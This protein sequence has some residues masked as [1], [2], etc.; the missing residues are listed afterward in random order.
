LERGLSIFP[1]LHTVNAR[2]TVAFYERLQQVSGAYLIPLMPFD[3][4]SLANNYKGLFP[5]GLRTDAYAECGTAILELLLH[6]L[7][8]SNIEVQAKLSVVLNTSHNGYDLMWC[9]LE[10]FVPGFDPTIPITQPQWSC[11][12]NILNFSQKH[13]LYF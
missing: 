6:L 11:D 12:G 13:C 8:T 2:E 5:P 7:P 10:L 1:K 4:I 9:V 3:T